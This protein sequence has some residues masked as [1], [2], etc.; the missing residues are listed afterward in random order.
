[1]RNLPKPA[2]PYAQLIRLDK[3]VGTWLLLWPSSWGIV[4]A[5]Y[6]TGAPI[7][8]TAWILSLFGVG[9]L[10]MRGA[11]CIVNDLWDRNL[12][13]K[14]ERT[15][16]RPIAS[17]A[18]SP[19]QAVIY[20]GSQ[21]L[22]GL[23]ILLALPWNCFLLGASSLAFVATYPLFKRFTYY[24]QL[25]LAFTYNWGAMLGFPAMDII[26]VPTM[27]TLYASGICWTMVYDTIYAHQ[28]KR[29]DVQAGIKSTAL[30]WHKHTK[31]IMTGFTV[32]QVS[33]LTA[34]GVLSGLGPAYFTGVGWAAYRLGRMI[35][36]VNLDQ[37]SD[38]WKWFVDNVKTGGVILAGIFLD[39]VLKITGL[40]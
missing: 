39:Y 13:K 32:A 23:A 21:L 5:A 22:I 14:V 3:P 38:C 31:P 36:C 33:L 1:M 16:M 29:D 27:A 28:D 19:K 6:M 8:H 34:T 17:G 18:V 11:G 10:V 2:L 37:P 4:T 30:A 25:M 24:P 9:A 20:L 15:A 7:G 26:D 35:M 12:D 40:L